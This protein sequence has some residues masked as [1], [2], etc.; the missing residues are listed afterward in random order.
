MPAP[1]T[2]PARANPADWTDWRWQMQNRI[3]SAEAL[4][5]WINPTP[6]EREA[7]EQTDD[8]FRWNVTPYYARYSSSS[9]TTTVAVM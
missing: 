6:D 3:H 1:S 9:I 8:I 2:I 5:D 4:A 7:I